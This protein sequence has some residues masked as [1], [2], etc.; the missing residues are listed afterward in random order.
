MVSLGDINI[1]YWKWQKPISVYSIHSDIIIDKIVMLVGDFTAFSTVVAK[2]N[3]AS[4]FYGIESL[5]N[6]GKS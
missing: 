1:G 6:E 5:D 3:F 2:R 4:G